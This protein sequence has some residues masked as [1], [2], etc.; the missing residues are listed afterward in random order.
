MKPLVWENMFRKNMKRWAY[1]F[2]NLLFEGVCV[3]KFAICMNFHSEGLSILCVQD[4]RCSDG[5][6]EHVFSHWPLRAL[7][8]PRHIPRHRLSKQRSRKKD[9]CDILERAPTFRYD[10]KKFEQKPPECIVLFTQRIKIQLHHRRD[11]PF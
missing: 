1:R 7:H 8:R 5:H 9:V 2:V 3:E 10:P 4:S 11:F 6:S